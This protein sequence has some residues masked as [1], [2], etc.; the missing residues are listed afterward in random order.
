MAE[1]PFFDGK[2]VDGPFLVLLR[3]MGP[4]GT[5]TSE[6]EVLEVISV[7]LCYRM[8]HKL[9]TLFPFPGEISISTSAWMFDFE[10]SISKT[11]IFEINYRIM[12]L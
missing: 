1:S 10:N 8:E 3:K 5:D 4:A 7:V 12:E 6:Q 2:N 9:E 11:E